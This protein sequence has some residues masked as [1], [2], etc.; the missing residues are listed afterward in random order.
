MRRLWADFNEIEGDEIWT[1]IAKADQ[2]AVSPKKGEGV[3]L[4]DY[5][6]NTCHARVLKVEGSVVTLT[7]D[8]STWQ[9][10]P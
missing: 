7:L 1:S 9:P 6:G 10:A 4:W 3:E 5:E 8:R 2:G